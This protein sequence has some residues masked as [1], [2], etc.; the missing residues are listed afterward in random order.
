MLAEGDSH[1]QKEKNP[2]ADENF[3]KGNRVEDQEKSAEPKREKSAKCHNLRIR[4]NNPSIFRLHGLTN[5]L[6]KRVYF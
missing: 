2:E 3:R 1:K 6:E 4:P 5:P